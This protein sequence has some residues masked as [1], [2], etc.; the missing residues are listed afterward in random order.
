MYTSTLY[1]ELSFSLFTY[2]AVHSYLRLS[3]FSLVWLWLYGE[4][5]YGQVGGRDPDTAD[6]LHNTQEAITQDVQPKFM[7][8]AGDE[9]RQDW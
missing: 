7:I 5:Y 8:G 9:Q 2:K 4:C 6:M 1:E 3:R